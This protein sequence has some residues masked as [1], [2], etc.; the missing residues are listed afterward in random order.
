ML[1]F[2]LW[3]PCFVNLL[4]YMNHPNNP[5]HENESD[6]PTLHMREGNI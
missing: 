3:K 5:I 4:I 2:N 6:F 1:F